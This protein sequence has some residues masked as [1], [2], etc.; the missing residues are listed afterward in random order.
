MSR[1]RSE[2]DASPITRDTAVLGGSTVF[3]GTRVPVKNLFD[4]LIAG[5]SIEEFL[6]DFPSVSR[7]QAAAVLRMAGERCAGP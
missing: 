4:H 6:K 2:V 1:G 5:Q 3:A 7:P